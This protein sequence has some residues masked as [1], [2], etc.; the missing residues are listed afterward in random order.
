MQATVKNPT[1]EIKRLQSCINDLISVLALP[2]IWSGSE[3]SDIVGTLLDVLLTM[4]RL[5][6][7]SVRMSDSSDGASL[8]VTRSAH[9]QHEGDGG[10]VSTAS[11]SLGIQHDVGVLVAGSR[12]PDFPTDVERLL[13]RVAANQAAIGL[14]EARRSGEQ[15]RVA[16]ELERQVAE[17]T[18]QLTAAN[19]ELERALGDIKKSED[20]FR[21]VI[22]T[23]PG[24]V[25]SGLPDGTF[26]FINQPWL[27]YLGCSWEELSARGGLRTVVHPDDVEAADARWLATR[28]SG[29]HT[30]H[31][32]RMR[33]AD[34]QYRWFLT[35]ALPLRDERGDIVRWYGTAT[36]IEDRKLAEESRQQAQ[37]DLA[38]VSRVTTMGELTA[39]LAHE[40]NQ[41]IAASLMNAGSCCAGSAQTRQISRKRAP[42][43]CES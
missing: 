43:R 7:A 36:D 24:M 23:I 32:L 6:F 14:Q 1:G 35:R 40:V 18:R 22:N 8:E 10:D 39:S 34:G 12:R 33:R 28:A 17:R 29:R 26:D 37:S 21:S 15:K 11:F 31:E 30:D 2:A 20:H 42:L 41:P 4:L 27:T 38:H 25:W 13:L 19:E 16:A 9:E 5:D 3:A